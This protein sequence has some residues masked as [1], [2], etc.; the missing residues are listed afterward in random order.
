MLPQTLQKK[1][2][3]QILKKC[4]HLTSPFPICTHPP[5]HVILN[6][7]KRPSKRVQTVDGTLLWSLGPRRA[8]RR[9]SCL[10]GQTRQYTLKTGETGRRG[11]VPGRRLAR[12]AARL[13]DGR[14]QIDEAGAAGGKGMEEQDIWWE[15]ERDLG[16]SIS[17]GGG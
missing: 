13:G 9:V 4:N 17:T 5:I 16:S 14:L 15:I 10:D 8:T 11:N 2:I 3:K 7:I 12:F 1:K 6:R